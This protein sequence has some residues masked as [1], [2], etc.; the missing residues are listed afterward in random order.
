VACSLLRRP[1]AAGGCCVYG[2]QAEGSFKDVCGI[3]R[4]GGH[5]QLLREDGGRLYYLAE[6]R[7]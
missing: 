5:L 6:V 1:G 4:G 7:G 2:E 3:G